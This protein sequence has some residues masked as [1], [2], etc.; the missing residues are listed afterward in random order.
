MLRTIIPFRSSTCIWVSAR[1]S[2]PRGSEWCFYREEKMTEIL[3]HQK[4]GCY[5][6]MFSFTQLLQNQCERTLHRVSGFCHTHHLSCQCWWKLTVHGIRQSCLCSWTVC[7]LEA[8]FDFTEKTESTGSFK[9]LKYVVESTIF[10][11]HP[12]KSQ[13]FLHYCWLFFCQITF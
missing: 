11:I 13:F 9:L 12:Q 10:K 1:R 5:L 3:L 6:Q 8:P 4:V 2:D 7:C